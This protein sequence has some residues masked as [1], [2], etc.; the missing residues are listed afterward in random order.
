M[1]PVDILLLGSGAFAARIAF[2]LAATAHAPVRIAI[3]A[4]NQPRLDWL[5]TAANARAII[6]GT[7][8]RIVTDQT[9]LMAPGAAAA[10][11]ARTR[12]RVVV[13]AASV[14]S[15]AVIAQ[16]G[17]AWSRLVAEG[18]LSATAIFQARLTAEVA[19]AIAARHPSAQL[20][21]CCFPDVVN[22]LIAAMGLPITC[23]T[24][25]VGILSNAFAGSLEPPRP[26]KLLAHYQ[27]IGA[28]RRP[29]AGR[30]G[31]VPR[32][33]VDGQEVPDV[34]TRFA[35]VLLTPEPALDIS[36][37]A[38]VPL[39][40]AMVSGG[41]WSGHVPGALG[42]PGGYPVRWTDGALS[43]DLPPGISRDDAVAWNASFE[44][45]C[46]LVLNG[47]KAS[48]T[49]RLAELLHAASPS[50]AQGFDVMALEDAYTAMHALR[51]QLLSQP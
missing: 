11:I 34:L 29:A 21:N 45:A 6:F 40:L 31:L 35:D 27:T 24:G 18:G 14:Q 44:Q 25:N 10:L 36:G 2:D 1:E 13:Q 51:T 33:W 50:I 41:S 12:P 28:W 15:G 8:A 4:R 38:G 3:A 48:Y 47:T 32:V 39:M 49:G 37:A 43:L 20:I 7:P 16:T 5:R 46:G 9:D 22:S 26:V 42:L 17:S 23:G 19:R 30:T